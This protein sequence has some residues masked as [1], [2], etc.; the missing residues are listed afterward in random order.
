MNTNTTS[1]TSFNKVWVSFKALGMFYNLHP[2]YIHTHPLKNTLHKCNFLDRNKQPSCMLSRYE[3]GVHLELIHPGS[4]ISHTEV[5]VP[6][7]S[8]ISHTGRKV[9]PGSRILHPGRQTDGDKDKTLETGKILFFVGC[10][11]QGEG[12]FI[13]T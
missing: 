7:G 1:K 12:P 3:W 2:Q 5:V 4:R 6:T 8:H 9:H 13:A 11:I 10:G